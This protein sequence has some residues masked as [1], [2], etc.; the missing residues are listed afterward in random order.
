MT[1][2]TSYVALIYAGL[3]VVMT[4]P[5]ARHLTTTLASDFG[6]PALNCWVL[7]WTAGQT[8]AALRGDVAAL[9]QYWNAN[10][11]YP[12]PLTLAYSEHL[13]PQM[14]LVLPVFAATDNIFLSY[15]LLFLSTFA[16]SGLAMYLFVRDLTARPLA[17]FVAGLA[18]AYAPYRLGQFP[19]LQVLSSF[20]MPLALL[21][22]RRY[23]ANRSLPALAGGVTAL[24]AQNLSC[25]YYLMFFSPFAAA[26][27]AYELVRRR[28]FGDRRVWISLTCAA[29]AVV[30]LTWPFVRPYLQLREGGQVG[31]RSPGDIAMFSADTQA[32]GTLAPSS[33]VRVWRETFSGYPKPE[34]GGFVGL[35]IATLAGIGMV[36]GIARRMRAVPW[37][38]LP[39][40]RLALVCASGLLLAASLYVVAAL[41]VEGHFTIHLAGTS[42]VFRNSTRPLVVALVSLVVFV[43]ATHSKAQRLLS[44][45]L[46]GSD[47]HQMRRGP[48]PGGEAEGSPS[49]AGHFDVGFFACALIA[50]ALLALGPRIEAGGQPL[51]PGPYAW[52]FELVPGFDGFRVP[53]RFLMLVALFLAVLAGL[54]AAALLARWRAA[55]AALVLAASVGILAEAWMAPMAL[56]A[57]IVPHD[58]LVTPR[59]LAVGKRLSPLYSMIQRL[60]DP[61]VLVEFPFG[62]PAYEIQAMVYAG[63]HRRPILNG[64]SG[65]FPA[66]YR[67]R[68]A[69]FRGLPSNFDQA[70]LDRAA[71]V[72]KASGATY[73]LV[74]EG[75]LQADLGKEISDWLASH[76]A[77]LAAS[78]GTD[79]LF[80]LR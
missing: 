69:A 60:P 66:S 73:A 37:S 40:W 6:D 54:G 35:T 10:I 36:F 13:T 63:H 28:L 22:F 43:A 29:A 53:A 21:G 74:H 72:L 19:H 15:N 32:F 62:E 48:T 4:W 65:F 39:A 75:A 50:A 3:A 25:G 52:L 14:L 78:D 47:F 31:V 55:A 7:M 18:F 26:Y 46:G 12:E 57:P 49:R 51:G 20:W 80:Q 24:V 30:L 45:P 58:P 61:V 8:L 59:R 64:Y 1:W 41:F 42:T 9:G 71:Q 56:S 77:R 27:C 33:R 76:G 79:K 68:A 38:S 5:L 17:A 11:F 44:S 16:L 70:D 23:F 2:R 34:G 67:E